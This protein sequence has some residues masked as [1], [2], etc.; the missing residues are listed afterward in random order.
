LTHVISVIKQK[1]S[2]LRCGKS[3]ECLMDVLINCTGVPVNV[4][5]DGSEWLSS[6]LCFFTTEEGT[7]P[8]AVAV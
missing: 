4:A 2:M 7:S 1:Q 8:S 6:S 5:V 3:G